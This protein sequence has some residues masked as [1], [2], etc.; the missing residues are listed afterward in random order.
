MSSCVRVAIALD[1]HIHA[2]ALSIIGVLRPSFRI[3]SLFRFGL[4]RRYAAPGDPAAKVCVVIHL[5]ITT[6]HE[7]LCHS[8][9][10]HGALAKYVCSRETL[11]YNHLLF[12]HVLDAVPHVFLRR[13]IWICSR[14][15]S[16]WMSACGSTLVS[17]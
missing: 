2:C 12:E 16:I 3:S 14:H 17:N 1:A 5:W 6:L 11:V 4:F 8:E 7:L 10:S 9:R 15:G 13:S